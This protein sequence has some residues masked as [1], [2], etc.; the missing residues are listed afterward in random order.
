MMPFLRHLS[1]PLALALS[2]VGARADC[3][4]DDFPRMDRMLVSSLG[5]GVQWNHLPMNGQTFRVPASV[6][7]VKG[8]YGR[9][10]EEAVDYSEFNGWEQ[11][12]HLNE[13]CMMLVQVKRQ[14]DRFSYGRFLLT[15][16]PARNAGEIQLGSGM[17]VPPGAQVISDMKSD[18]KIREG[19]LVLLRVEDNLHATNAWYET[20]LARQ[21]WSLEQRSRQANGVVLNYSKGRELMSVGL[22]RHQDQTQVLVNRMGR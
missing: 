7:E 3:D 20:E 1:L 2:S 18:D 22:L 12:F 5:S 16:P 21:G 17:P 15:N 10:W 19:R 14:N 13:D 8:F 9:Q 4:Y 6:D 11:I